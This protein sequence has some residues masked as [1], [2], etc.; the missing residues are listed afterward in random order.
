MENTKKKSPRFSP[1]VR[2]RAVR[3]V[4]EHQGERE[5][6][7]KVIASIAAKFGCSGETLR[8]WV[9]KEERDRGLRPGT[10]TQEQDRIKELEREVRELRQVNEIL[11]KASAY[12]APGGARPPTEVMITFIDDHRH[13][14]GVEPICRV[15]PIAPS[16]YYKHVARRADPGLVPPRAR[17]DRMLKDEI[18]RVWEENFQVYGA[19]KVWKQLRREGIVVA[20]CTV[21]RLMKLMGLRGV[22]RGKT[23][24]TT[25][26]DG[27]TPCPKDLVNRQF[28]AERPNALWVSDFT[29]VSSW[30][31]F[32][33]VAF[34]ID[35]FARRIVGWRASN[36][37]R[38]DFVLDAL[39]QALYER[40]PAQ[41]DGL[42]HHSDR[43]AQYVSIRYTDRLVD[44]GIEPSVGSA[45]DSYDNA[46]AETINGLYKAEVIHRLGPWR[47]LQ[48]V[49]MATLEWVDWFNNRRLFGPIGHI[50]PAEAEAAYYS[51]LAGSA[52]GA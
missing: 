10:S 18:R 24:R 40:Q 11:R 42:I 27:S 47:N 17:R 4:L 25:V 38:T 30:Q 46:L 7:W 21:E 49:E 35:V 41:Q 12:F 51:K 6:Q 19:D 8:S 23:V 13:V 1:E 32:V 37:A 26:S 48:A 28:T 14:Y 3:M 15:L 33:Y 45:G 20:R 34:I 50:P 31:G 5:S 43:G 52:I 39:E 44:A 9:R 2:E 29:Y 22:V 16:T 36:S